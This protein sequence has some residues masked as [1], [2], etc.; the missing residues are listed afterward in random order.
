MTSVSIT[1]VT[2]SFGATRAVDDVTLHVPHGSFTTV[3]GPSGCGKTTLL[4]LIA[5]FL[6]PESG[7]IAFGD[8]TVAGDGVRPVAPQARRVG[9]VPQEGALFP[10]L[11]VAANIAFGLPREARGGGRGRDRVAEMLDLVELPADFRDRRP[12]ELSGGQQQRVALARSLAPQPAVVLL[13]EPFSSLDASLRGSTA[14]AVRRALEA[15]NTTALLVTHDQNEALS[16]ADQVAVMRAGRLVQSAPPS[17][18]YL[19]PTDPQV[20]EFVGR[21]VVL[22]GTATDARATCA[23]GEVVLTEPTTGPVALMIRPEQVFVD[24]AHDEG[25]RGTVEEVSYY[26]HDCA[27]QVRLDEGTS[28]LARMA[29]VRH[30]GP[31]D[32]VHLRVTGLVRAYHP[33]GAE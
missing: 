16:L 25:V 8:T 10:H 19:S 15:T 14:R 29:G 32:V 22:P 3:L 18:V 4:R 11:D 1:G 12:D 23:L 24:L 33:A 26:G 5:G 17:E 31:G 6:L 20:A 21:A 13:D 30:P 28:V 9:Y 2:K 7:N 27:V